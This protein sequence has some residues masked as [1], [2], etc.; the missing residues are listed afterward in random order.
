MA[1][2]WA[3]LD[4]EDLGNLP[5]CGE[6]HEVFIIQGT[7]YASDKVSSIRIAQTLMR[8]RYG[9]SDLVVYK[10]FLGKPHVRNYP[11]H[12][13]ISHSGG[14]FVVAV[15]S[16]LIGIDVERRRNVKRWRE[17]YDWVNAPEDRIEHPSLDDFLRCWTAK[18]AL[19]KLNGMGLNYG[20]HR[21][22][23]RDQCASPFYPSYGCVQFD[24]YPRWLTYL[25]AWGD[26]TVAL[27][28]AEPCSVRT[29]LLN[30]LCS[31]GSD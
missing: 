17:I 30:W 6:V 1:A 27:A 26:L 4:F 18:E 16:V 5:R 2:A 23:L 20:L 24:G 28:M 15:S 22:S 10:D 9:F 31:H 29:F 21:I 12:V 14:V 11:L 7:A 25:P 3:S 19:V 8:N 13:S